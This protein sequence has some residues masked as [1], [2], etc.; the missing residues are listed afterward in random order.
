MAPGN[1]LELDSPTAG[2]PQEAGPRPFMTLGQI[3]A[4]RALLFVY[5]LTVAVL[6]AAN[7]P[8][9][10]HLVFGLTGRYLAARIVL[11]IMASAT[12][13]AFCVLMGLCLY[14]YLKAHTGPQPARFWLW[15]II[16]ANFVGIVIYY[17]L[18]VEPEQRRLLAPRAPA[19]G[20]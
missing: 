13:L 15:V 7:V 12:V 6:T 5:V 8:A 1:L 16:L 3:V 17:T 2:G 10:A 19:A 14:H 9:V 18:I 11:G 20:V 4:V